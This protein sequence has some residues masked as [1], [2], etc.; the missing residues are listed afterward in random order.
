MAQVKYAKIPQ[1]EEDADSGSIDLKLDEPE[2]IEI[3]DLEESVNIAE[4]SEESLNQGENEKQRKEKLKFKA[5]GLTEK[6]LLLR[7]SEILYLRELAV[8]IISLLDS[9]YPCD[10]H[11]IF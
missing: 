2:Q 3:V 9:V 7:L 6:K 4:D 1:S 5:I 10:E 11:M 8:Y